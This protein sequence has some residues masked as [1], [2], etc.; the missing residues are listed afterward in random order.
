MFYSRRDLSRAVTLLEMV[1]RRE[2]KKREQI[3]ITKKVFEK[4]YDCRDFSG[5][6]VTDILTNMARNAR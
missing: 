1:R 6:L 2:S 4:R 5:Q 3:E